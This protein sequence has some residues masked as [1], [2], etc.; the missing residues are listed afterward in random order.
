VWGVGVCL[1]LC[2]IGGVPFGRE[3][4]RDR[5]LPSFIL[6]FGFFAPWPLTAIVAPGPAMVDE[7]VQTARHFIYVTQIYFCSMSSVLPHT[8]SAHHPSHV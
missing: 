4:T 1:G 6:H 7:S 5:L 3:I 8:S 2:A